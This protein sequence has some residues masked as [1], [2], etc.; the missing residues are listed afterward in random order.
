MEN[1]NGSIR[2]VPVPIESTRWCNFTKQSNWSSFNDAYEYWSESEIIDGVGF[3][4]TFDDD[5]AFIDLDNCYS[6]E[7][8][9]IEDWASSVLSKINSYSEVSPSGTGIHIVAKGHLL[10]HGE[11]TEQEI[12]IYDARKFMTFTG[13]HLEECPK[14]LK[15]RDDRLREITNRYL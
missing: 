5:I 8:D 2:K 10:Q 11:S 9:E 3:C 6:I 14:E 7:S 15:R 1:E 12:E 4:L 13:H